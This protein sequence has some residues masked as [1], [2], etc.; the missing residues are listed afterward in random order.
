VKTEGRA[1][2]TQKR[3]GGKKKIDISSTKTT[4]SREICNCEGRGRA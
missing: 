4:A 2:E 1:G 3:Q